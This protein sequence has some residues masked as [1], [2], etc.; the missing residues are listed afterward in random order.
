M[1]KKTTTHYIVILCGGTGPRLWPLSKT[2]K[3]KQ[4]LKVFSNNSFLK[5]TFL[6]AQKI[7]PRKNIYVVSNQKYLSL[8]KN[9]LKNLLLPKNII[10]EPEKKN[11]AL[12]ILYAVATIQKI[13]PHA[14]ITSMPS[15]HFIG[16][17]DNFVTDVKKTMSIAKNGKYIVTLGIKPN[18]PSTSFGYILTN[19]DSQVLKFIEKPDL[20]TAQKLISEDYTFWNSGLYTFKIDCLI[21]EFKQHSPEYIPLYNQLIENLNKPKS[22]NKVYSL[23]PSLAIDKAIS[24]KSKNLFLVP[25]TFAWNDVG[26][27][28]TIYQQ[29]PKV[30]NNISILNK[31]T[32]YVEVNS[33]NCLI[34]ST[35]KNK[36]IGL[37]D[38]DNLAIIN[39]DEAL[40]IC[41]I[42]S[43]GSYH[44]R[45]LVTKIVSNKKIKHYFADKND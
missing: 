27:W 15:D 10:S 13:D 40:L 21:S 12:A 37:V 30:E 16:K 33:Q 28:K 35:Q 19:K 4:F 44:V 6:R 29:L 18:S 22:I 31:N 17:L 5:D 26:E 45:D 34:S 24:E 38:V 11:T 14:V 3:P 36:L 25:V 9:D 7:V 2:S 39:T 20:L 41:N 42:S 8:I 43:N 1:V 32:N 23:S